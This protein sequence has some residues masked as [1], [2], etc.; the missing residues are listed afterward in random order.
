VEE[1]P[2]IETLKG[3]RVGG[4]YVVDRVLGAGGMGVVA[5]A[6][7]PELHQKVAIKFL[8]PEHSAN[9]TLNARFVRE[10]RIAAQVKSEHFVRVFDIGKLPNGIPYL[11]MELLAGRDLGDELAADGAMPVDRAVDYMLQATVGL[12][13]IHALGVV[14]RDLKPSNLF[15]AEAGGKRVIKVLDFG[16]SK[17]K[18]KPDSGA[19]LTSTENL[20]GTPQYM[21]PEQV[22]ASKEVDART[23]IWSLGVILYELLA[24]RRPFVSDEN[25]VGELF[26]KVMYIDPPPLTDFRSDLP[27]GLADVIAKC[28]SRD[29]KQRYANVGELAEALRPFAPAT[30]AHRIESVFQA[31]AARPSLAPP[32]EGFDEARHSQQAT[33]AAHDVALAPTRPSEPLVEVVPASITGP[34]K[35]SGP[36]TSLTSSQASASRE[37]PR[38]RWF[39]FAIGIGGI[40]LGAALFAL[41]TRSS[42][43]PTGITATPTQASSSAPAATELLPPALILPS[44]TAT[45]TPTPTTTPTLTAKTADS[46]S[47]VRPA[48][49]AAKPR[50]TVSTPPA[51]PP[52]PAPAPPK[53]SGTADL[54][55]D[56][57]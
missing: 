57:K 3:M 25:A 24:N 22:K 38:G 39:G 36:I 34:G 1:R 9:T 18:S 44:A 54:I 6:R 5:M 11:V 50:A 55:M 40:A 28:L 35:P 56:R 33:Q 29:L 27:A 16:I 15:V 30:S 10:G 13:E 43:P 45:P 17:E 19:S 26:A 7:Y 49:A 46:P 31:L 37:T 21:S 51:A 32:S 48:T 52:K 4:R 2:F 42:T 41:A 23:D 47:V 20:L 14:H 12:A 53:P 8:L